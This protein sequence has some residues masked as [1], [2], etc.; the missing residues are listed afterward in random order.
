M[1]RMLV[2]TLIAFA[3]GALAAPTASAQAP[4]P[5]VTINGL[6]DNVTSYSQN[7]SNFNTGL[8]NRKDDM[9]YGRTRGRFDFIGEIGKAKGVLGLELDEVYGL[10]GSSESNFTNGCGT[11]STGC[12]T[13]VAGSPTIFSGLGSDGSFGLNTDVRGQLEIKWL[14]VEFPVPLI[15]VPTTA[16]VGAQPFGAA[17]TYKLCVYSCSDFAGLNVTSQVT[18]NLKVLATYVQVTEGLVGVQS[19]TN[20]PFVQS[21]G[22][23][24]TQARGDD[25]AYILS[26]E[27]MP[28]RGLDIKPMLS[29]FYGNGRTGAASSPP[30]VGRG[31]INPV[32]D[33]TNPDGTVRGGLNEYRYTVGLDSRLRMGPFS[34]DPTVLYQFG[35]RGVIA[36]ATFADSGAVPGRRYNADISAWLVDIRGGFQLGPLLLEGLVVYSSGNSA[37][38]NTLNK[39]RYF[40]PL[41]TD[42]GYQADW[43]SQLTGLGIDYLNAWNEAGGRIAYPGVSIGWD[44]YGRIQ[45]GGKAT[46]AITPALSVMGGANVHWTDEKVDRNGIP[47]AGAGI[48]PVWDA[49]KITSI[50]RDPSRYVGTELFGVITW[51]FADGLSWDNSV[52]YM[53]MG[54]ALDAVTDPAAGPRNTHNPFIV[55]SRVRLTF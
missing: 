43:G 34:L 50:H 23:S 42:T 15:P 7:I 2:L 29:M 11:T 53:F 19:K 14:Y 3:L 18:P 31:G 39:V 20:L 55:S 47:V 36:P 17:S 13:G 16:R 35:S 22:A 32:T 26:T 54:S 30:R 51:R 28:F 33:F 52:G 41:S 37:R 48:L 5:K 46:Y 10:T 12:A 49:A 40:Q 45:V 38:N 9:W 21:G 8:F 1:K 6:I 27:V 44:K 24:N 25:F 4:T